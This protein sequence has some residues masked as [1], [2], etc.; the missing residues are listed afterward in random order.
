M[1]ARGRV[2]VGTADS[3]V[4][5]TGD[6]GDGL[7][8]VVAG[9]DVADDGFVPVASV[10]PGDW[11]PAIVVDGAVGARPES[12][13]APTLASGPSAPSL[14]S[15]LWVAVSSEGLT[16]DPGDSLRPIPEANTAAPKPTTATPA[17]T[18]APHPPTA[19]PIR[20]RLVGRRNSSA[21]SAGRE[22]SGR[23]CGGS[24]SAAL[25]DLKSIGSGVA[26]PSC[27]VGAAELASAEP[28]GLVTNHLPAPARLLR[29]PVVVDSGPAPRSSGSGG[30]CGTFPGC[31]RS[32]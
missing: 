3:G 11:A 14:P 12:P 29:V 8:G 7:A 19:D 28:P 6:D 2:V 23:R 17:I 30:W 18:S 13:P 16:T 4:E 25:D 5:P 22:P 26:P 32:T 27:P 24:S 31:P 20:C 9:R 1:V 21:V 10:E 15:S